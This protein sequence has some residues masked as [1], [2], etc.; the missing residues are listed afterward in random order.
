RERIVALIEAVSHRIESSVARLTRVDHLLD[1]FRQS[2]LT[3]ACSGR[4]TEEWRRTHHSTEP[5]P[6]GH[7][8]STFKWKGIEIPAPW[9]WDYLGKIAN[10]KL[11][12][13]LDRRKN[14]GQPTPYLRNI[15]VRWFSFDLDDLLEMKVQEHEHLKYSIRDG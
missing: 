13:M 14:Q 10:L 11:G 6:R 7:S 2:V 9:S 4:L 12:K 15:N 3:A 5:G 1:R 8:G